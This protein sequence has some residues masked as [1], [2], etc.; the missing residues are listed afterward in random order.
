M[1][2]MKNKNRELPSDFKMATITSDILYASI[3][4]CLRAIEPKKTES[5]PATL[6]KSMSIRVNVCSEIVN[7]IKSLGYKGDMAYNQILYPSQGESRKLLM[8]LIDIVPKKSM[9]ASTTG[10]V[11]TQIYDQIS[12]ELKKNS[13]SILESLICFR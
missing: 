3:L 13:H 7:I 4:N 11:E 9:G 12:K 2:K 5:I 1:K 10:I 6:P 8:W